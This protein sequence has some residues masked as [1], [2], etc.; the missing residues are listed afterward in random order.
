M[1]KKKDFWDIADEVVKESHVDS[2]GDI[3]IQLEPVNW[4]ITGNTTSSSINYWSTGYTTYTTTAYPNFD[5]RTVYTNG[6]DCWAIPN[7]K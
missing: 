5:S 2:I 6:V 7:Y 4:T 3:T 1:R